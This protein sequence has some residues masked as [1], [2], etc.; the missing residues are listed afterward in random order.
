MLALPDN[1]PDWTGLADE[2]DL[3]LRLPD[4]MG[5]PSGLVMRFRRIPKGSFFMGSRGESGWEE[6]RHRVAVPQ[7]FWLGKFVVTQDEYAAVVRGLSALREL[8]PD[9][10]DFNGGRRP[11]ESVSWDD[12]TAW[13]EALRQWDGLPAGIREIRLPTEAEWEYACRAGTE[14]DYHNGDGEAALREIGWFGENSGNETHP[15]DAMVAGKPERRRAGLV[16]MHGNVWEWCRDVFDACAYRKRKDPWE[17][18]E[19]TLEAAGSDATRWGDPL[20]LGESPDRVLRG[21]SWNN[22]ASKCRSAVRGRW[23]PDVRDRNQG[24]RVCLVP[25]PAGKGGA[26][27]SPNP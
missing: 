18:Q 3:E 16:G 24:F 27:S 25:G 13:C 22:V 4:A 21:G 6:P 20:K 5:R 19:W 23:K 8:E 11:V 17:A 7:E 10:S 1:Q 15:V 14:T 12:A 2:P 9:P 26:G